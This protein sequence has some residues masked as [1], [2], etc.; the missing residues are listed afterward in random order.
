MPHITEIHETERFQLPEN[1]EVDAERAEEADRQFLS[2]DN[3]LSLAFNAVNPLRQLQIART[4]GRSMFGRED[5]LTERTEPVVLTNNGRNHLYIV[6]EPLDGDPDTARNSVL[7]PG[8]TEIADRGGSASRVHNEYANMFSNRRVISCITEGMSHSGELRRK[9]PGEQRRLEHMAGDT[10]RLLPKL[11]RNGPMEFV[12]TSLGSRTSMHIAEQNLAANPHEMINLERMKL[13]A[14]AVIACNV[15]PA[16][17]F[18]TKKTTDDRMRAEL[19]RKFI[20]HICPELG[21]MTLYNPIETAECS[22]IIT[23]YV[24]NPKKAPARLRAIIDDFHDVQEGIDWQVLKQISANYKIMVLGGSR[25]PLVQWQIP[26][27]A[28]LSGMYP[29]NITQR[30]LKG[31]GHL[32]SVD[33]AGTVRELAELETVA[34]KKQPLAVAA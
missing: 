29:G 15:P 12:A 27:W 5:R 31:K 11:T 26:Q 23:E 24:L 9:Y 2:P 10:M 7:I 14:S 25:D 1:I 8:L 28:A 17:R 22:G 20:T 21:R 3:T 30:V 19:T 16:E 32:M 4:L 33:A 6:T 34:D 18:Y 13:V